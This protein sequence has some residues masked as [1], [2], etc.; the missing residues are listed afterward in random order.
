MPAPR[1]TFLWTPGQDAK[2]LLGPTCTLVRHSTT[3]ILGTYLIQACPIQLGG[4]GSAGPD[5][6]LSS[7]PP[8]SA[9]VTMRS[10]LARGAAFAPDQ[11]IGA[12]T[13]PGGA[14]PGHPEHLPTSDSPASPG[15]PRQAPASPGKPSVLA[16]SRR[17]RGML[18][19]VKVYGRWTGVAGTPC[20][21]SQPHRYRVACL[22]NVLVLH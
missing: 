11:E 19:A 1:A 16:S 5:C 22:V 12:L 3:K 7:P 13:Q 8:G 21:V 20:R 2:P 17:S 14:L 4:D 10:R 18:S 9:A 6:D 15:K